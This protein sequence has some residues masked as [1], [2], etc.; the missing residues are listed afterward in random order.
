MKEAYERSRPITIEM[1]EQAKE[2]IIL[3]RQ[4][5]IDQLADKLQ[6]TRVRQVIGPILEGQKELEQI[7]TIPGGWSSTPITSVP[8]EDRQW[9]RKS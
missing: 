4:T 2:N 7:F 8:P 3:R 6:E 1:I 9:R 5:H